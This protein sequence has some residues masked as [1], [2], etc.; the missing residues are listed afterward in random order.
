MAA[1]AL[2]GGYM[3]GWYLNRLSPDIGLTVEDQRHRRPPGQAVFTWN[4]FPTVVADQL[5]LRSEDVRD[6]P[7]FTLLT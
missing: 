5:H 6:P 4:P 7:Q 3:S 2:T 1:Q